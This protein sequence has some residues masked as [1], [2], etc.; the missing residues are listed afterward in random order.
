MFFVWGGRVFTVFG[1]EN[2]SLVETF[3]VFCRLTDRDWG[4]V[5]LD[6]KVVFDIF[7]DGLA[8]ATSVSR[9]QRGGYDT[10][11]EADFCVPIDGV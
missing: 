5:D 3:N 6:P 9:C 2:K 1:D 7:G 10:S 8:V 11:S 4:Q